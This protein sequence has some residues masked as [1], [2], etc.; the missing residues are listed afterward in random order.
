MKGSLDTVAGGRD[1]KEVVIALQ[2]EGQMYH[3]CHDPRER[4][5]GG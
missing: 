4:H 5:L 3:S 1:L 2:C